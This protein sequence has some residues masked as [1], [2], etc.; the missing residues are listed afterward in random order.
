MSDNLGDEELRHLKRLLNEYKRRLYQLEEKIAHEWPGNTS[1]TLQAEDIRKEIE[2]LQQQIHDE[3]AYSP[4]VIPSLRCPYPGMEPFNRKYAEYF[5]GREEDILRILMDLHKGSHII[6]II[7]PSGSGKSSLV[8][9]GVLPQ[10]ETSTLFDET[11]WRVEK[12][13]ADLHRTDILSDIMQKDAHQLNHFIDDLLDTQPVPKQKLLLIIDSLEAIFSQVEAE[14]RATFITVLKRLS[15]IERCKIIL[16]IRSDFYDDLLKSELWPLVEFGLH[17]ITQLRSE[18]LAQAI[19]KPALKYEVQIEHDLVNRL[20]TD[21]ASAEVP[22]PLVQET[23][24]LLWAGRQAN[25]LSLADYE[26]LGKDGQSGLAIAIAQQAESVVGHLPKQQLAIARRIFL[27]LVDF[28]AA[29]RITR[30]LQTKEALRSVTRQ[31]ELFDKIFDLLVNGRLL[32]SARDAFVSEP[33]VGISHEALFS[34]WPRFTHWIDEFRETE[35][36]RQRLDMK[37][38]EWQKLEEKGGLLDVVQL[39]EADTWLT[40]IDAEEL[41]AGSNLMRLIETSR[42]KIEADQRE[43]KEIINKL[44]RKVDELDSVLNVAKAL[45]SSLVTKE[46]M[47]TLIS[48][49]SKQLSVDTVIVWTLNN[50]GVLVPEET[51]GIPPEMRT[52]RVPL[53]Q[54]LT[55]QVASS[56]DHVSII[57]VQQGHQSIYPEIQNNLDLHSYL[58]VP[59]KFQGETIG[60]LSVMSQQVREFTSDEIILI[61]GIASHTAIALHNAHEYRNIVGEKDR[62]VEILDSLMVDMRQIVQNIHLHLK[63][64]VDDNIS[65]EQG[66]SKANKY[67]SRL[68]DMLNTIN[69]MKEIET[70]GLI[71][72]KG[73][74]SLATPLLDAVDMLGEDLQEKNIVILSNIKEDLPEIEG[75]QYR[76]RRVFTH[77]LLMAIKDFPQEIVVRMQLHPLHPYIIDVLIAYESGNLPASKFIDTDFGTLLARVVIEKHGGSIKQQERGL[78]LFSLPGALPRSG[79]D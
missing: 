19:T 64:S 4:K 25:K 38:D 21:A 55:G 40:R 60:V 35:Q 48:E 13:Q 22:L 7:G 28:S 72:K 71:L 24:R 59:V 54:G 50:E 41:A 70:G 76:M 34:A 29:A 26:E 66:L 79:S 11:S 6:T 27:R 53:G 47:D 36:I 73:K 23:M 46:I 8:F 62:V 44:K 9:A 42:A 18:K 20:I 67:T 33:F 52:L 56:D 32:W 78:F 3:E 61:K 69:D 75:D 2:K 15:H 58:G 5:H 49:V 30:R 37:V 74:M 12:T 1:D 51:R 14:E 65:I 68:I 45:S 77:L 10:L 31:P 43:Q 17:E 16:L 63:L 39:A 57:D